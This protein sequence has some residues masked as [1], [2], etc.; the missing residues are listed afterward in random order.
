M[1]KEYCHCVCLVII[2]IDS[3]FKN[4]YLTVLLEKWKHIL[5]EKKSLL[6][7]NKKFFLM[8]LIILIILIEGLI[9]RQRI[10]ANTEHYMCNF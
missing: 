2:L 3:V 1:P 6:K 4:Y 9:K 7:M 10:Y 8:S 5:K